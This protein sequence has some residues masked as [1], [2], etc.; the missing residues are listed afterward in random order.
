MQASADK[1]HARV[2]SSKAPFVVATLRI[3]TR[4]YEFVELVD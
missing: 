3:M 1:V 4:R 2:K